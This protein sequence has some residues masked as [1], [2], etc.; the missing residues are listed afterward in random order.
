MKRT[1]IILSI[2]LIGG[3][4]ANIKSQEATASEEVECKDGVCSLKKRPTFKATQVD[5]QEF[6]DANITEITVENFEIIVKQ[7]SKPVI[8]DFY[9]QWCGPCKVVKPIFAE[10]AKEKFDWIFATVDVDKAPTIMAACKISAMPTFVIFKDGVQWGMIS[11][12]KSKEELEAEF[13]RIIISEQPMQADKSVLLQQLIGAI[14]KKEIATIKS[15]IDDGADLNGVMEMKP[16]K[17]SPLFAAVISGT[18]EIID[19]LIE[20]GINIDATAR[21]FVAEQIATHEESLNNLIQCFEYAQTKILPTVATQ[22]E[23]TVSDELRQKFISGIIQQDE[24]IIKDIL[25]ENISTNIIFDLGIMKITPIY[26]A[27]LSNKRSIV[28]ILMSAGASLDIEI[29]S[30][31]GTKGSVSDT[32]KADIISMQK[33]ADT[34]R[35]NFDYI[36]SKA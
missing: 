30:M 36:V 23:T 13:N 8:I 17:I 12:L 28:D 18:T 21:E 24:N 11:G 6:C 27:I 33:S 29:V 35:A 26:L 15:L 10:L 34:A 1:N 31:A 5:A 32:I 4:M 20:A 14:N 16:S 7:A 9:A 19:I 25:A 22:L 2:I 3:F